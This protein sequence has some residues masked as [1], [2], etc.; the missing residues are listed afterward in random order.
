MSKQLQKSFGLLA[1][2]ALGCLVAVWAIQGMQA[3]G[4]GKGEMGGAGPRYSVVDTEGH[5][6]IVTDN[7]S[8]ILYFY[9]IDK[10]A[11]I[12]SD[13]KLRG[14]LDLNQV[15]KAVLSPILT[16]KKGG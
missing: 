3:Q 16:K 11:E 1:A 10:D 15:G 4:G 9:T 7:K 13:L 14:S 6:L 8:N 12:G 2:L 5:N